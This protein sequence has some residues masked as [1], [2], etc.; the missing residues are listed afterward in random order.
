MMNITRFNKTIQ[1]RFEE[2]A[3]KA[4]DLKKLLKDVK[5]DSY[6]EVVNY[7]LTYTEGTEAYHKLHEH[8]A[9]AY[10]CEYIEIVYELH[11]SIKDLHAEL[12]LAEEQCEYEKANELST[13][14]EYRLSSHDLSDIYDF[15]NPVAICIDGKCYTLVDIDFEEEIPVNRTKNELEEQEAIDWEN[16]TFW[17]ENLDGRLFYYS[18]GYEY[19]LSE[20]EYNEEEETFWGDTW[21]ILYS[22]VSIASIL[23]N[24]DV[25]T[26]K[27][28]E[29]NINSPIGS[30]YDIVYIDETEMFYLLGQC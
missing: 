18:F 16:L 3:T 7:E 10:G 30:Y 29:K 19:E 15:N 27:E 1:E 25:K 8:V 12:A 21:E 13:E 2:A 4:F 6:G 14:Y 26:L 11:Q 5:N 22:D 28:L 24:F 20:I 9:A 23:D 17:Y